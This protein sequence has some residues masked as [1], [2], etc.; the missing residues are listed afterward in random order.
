MPDAH[1]A[2]TADGVRALERLKTITGDDPVNVNRKG[3]MA[4]HTRLVGRFTIT[5][6]ELP[7][8]PDRAAALRRRLL[9]IFFPHSF[10]GRED[11]GLKARI[12]AE[13]PGII[14]W[15]LAG[16]R[17]IRIEQRWSDPKASGAVVQSW[18]T[19]MAPVLHFLRDECVLEP[20]A[21]VPKDQLYAAY[22][23]WCGSQGMDA[24]PRTRFGQQLLAVAPGVSAGRGSRAEYGTRAHLY[25]QVRLA[26][27]LEK[28]ARET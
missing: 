24:L 16:L 28:R 7:D 3:L 5:V 12:A 11:E 13:G 19:Q 26:S 4:I 23:H 10:E 21:A 17:R 8:L 25:R 6:N 2:R 14:N 18:Q 22:H 9:L 20:D 27:L 15:A 1:M